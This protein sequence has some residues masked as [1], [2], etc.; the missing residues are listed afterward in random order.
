MTTSTRPEIDDV[1]RALIAGL[2]E[3]GRA[4]YAALA[5]QVG[6]SQAAVRT[7]V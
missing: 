1:D 6:L 4:T 7:R 5:P 2:V 3:N